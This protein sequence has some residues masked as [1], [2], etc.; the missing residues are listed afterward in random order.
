MY[1]AASR[2]TLKRK[3]HTVRGK[4]A[5]SSSFHRMEDDE[6]LEEDYPSCFQ[7]FQVITYN[8][9]QLETKE[10][11]SLHE[12]TNT[13]P[14]WAT[15]HW[16]NI[17]GVDADTLKIL[18]TLF[19]LHPLAVE[20]VGELH[21]KPKLAWYNNTLFLLTS[22]IRANDPQ[23][24]LTLEQISF[25]VIGKLVLT[26]QAGT[27]GDVFNP[28]RTQLTNPKA[29]LRHSDAMFLLY[30][31]LDSLVDECQS[32]VNAVDD[33]LADIEMKLLTKPA[34]ELNKNIYGCK[35]KIVVMRSVL[36]PTRRMI[37]TLLT[38]HHR[39][40]KYTFI[41]ANILD[42]SDASL[43]DNE[44]PHSAIL[45]NTTTYFRDIFDLL[46]QLNETLDHQRDTS[47]SLSALYA[48]HQAHRQ[49]KVSYVI[50]IVSA[51]FLPLTFVAG[52]Y[53]MNFHYMPELY[54]HYGYLF[55]WLVF[56]SIVIG[57]IIA[58]WCKGYITPFG[59]EC[60]KIR[61]KKKK[62]FFCRRHFVCEEVTA[63]PNFDKYVMYIYQSQTEAFI[64]KK[65]ILLQG[66]YF[67]NKT[68]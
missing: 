64:P 50:A 45:Q 44:E 29:K 55:V 30:A 35:R 5:S 60:I 10:S 67:D 12:L 39:R 62:S 34:R 54:W 27:P 28:I 16:I 13:I 21:N 9:K 4:P 65:A 57:L 53:G 59:I 24:A 17:E 41:N 43:S 11:V 25:F 8:D 23:A 42:S 49:E 48:E 33:T 46:T 1:Q 58:F 14:E 63:F 36:V 31:L 19:D 22:I 18:K 37:G 51:F 32:L 66:F 2:Y 52:V 6:P 3:S 15:V 20:D 68:F 38:N 47:N 26:I 7:S 40:E 61:S 56:I